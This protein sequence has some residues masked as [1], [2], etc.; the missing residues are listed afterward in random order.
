[1][2]GQLKKI[3][4]T[5]DY[6]IKNQKLISGLTNK[7]ESEKLG[8]YTIF[9]LYL[10]KCPRKFILSEISVYKFVL[11]IITQYLNILTTYWFSLE[12]ESIQKISFQ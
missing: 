5:F 7:Q 6:E 11:L 10:L 8:Q 1:M 2:Q 9:I 3:L 4:F 12:E